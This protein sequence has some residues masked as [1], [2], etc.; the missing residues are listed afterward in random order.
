MTAGM[1]VV[2]RPA[3]VVGVDGSERNEAAVE[4]AVAEALAQD[5]PLLLVVAVDDAGPMLDG[6]AT[7]A[8]HYEAMLAE[9]RE[10]IVAVHPG[11]AVHTSV[12]FGHPV[13]ML[14]DRTGD[15]DLLVVGK[16]G[17]GP[18]R[19]LLVGSTSIRTAS[20]SPAPVIVV[21]GDWRAAER[22]APV[23]VG[24][25]PERGHDE[26]LR[27]AFERA[28]LSDSRV[29][30]VYAVDMELVLVVGAAAVVTSDVH[31]W[32]VRSAAAIEDALKPFREEYVDVPVEIVHDRA[33]AATVLL[34][35]SE[36]AQL[37]VLSRQ[38][39]G[40]SAWGLGKVARE[41]LHE[42]ELPVAIVPCRG[43]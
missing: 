12:R 31:D 1:G 10:R 9:L 39:R 17:L 6:A 38:H 15:D 19:R 33:H 23:V 27:F 42:A 41:V 8:D 3:V 21:P 43:D 22:T 14:L 40:P 36:D 7:V 25:D 13:G 34:E 24:I 2:P 28:Q 16:R 18:L 29:R 26:A 35:R 11:M 5:R 32:E 4:Y 37:V 30:V 20:W